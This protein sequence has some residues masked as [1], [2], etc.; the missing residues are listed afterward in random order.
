MHRHRSKQKLLGR[1]RK[2][3]PRNGRSDDSVFNGRGRNKVRKIEERTSFKDV[4]RR[5]SSLRP[6]HFLE[7]TSIKTK[8]SAGEG[9]GE[10]GK[11][12]ATDDWRTG[13]LWIR[14]PL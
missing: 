13:A 14:F 7:R 12:F 10:R 1:N 8:S 6:P 11:A 9:E 3:V 4:Q 2:D 5:L